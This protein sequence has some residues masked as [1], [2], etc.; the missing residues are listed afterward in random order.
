MTRGDPRLGAVHCSCR[1]STLQTTR[2]SPP[3]TRDYP[4]LPEITASHQAEPAAFFS[5]AAATASGPAIRL[6]AKPSPRYSRDAVEI[7]PRYRRD[8]S[9]TQS[10]SRRDAAEVQ[11]RCRRG[12]GE[13]QPRYSR[14][15]DLRHGCRRHGRC[16]PARR[17]RH[18]IR[19]AQRAAGKRRR[20]RLGRVNR[21]PSHT[22]GTAGST[23]R[24][25]T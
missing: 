16:R 19:R 10:R 23:L 3:I 18:L 9:E 15:T 7:S 2:R 8:L 25:T 17:S 24:C 4:R 11:S 1:C 5:F 21:S 20:S 13:V 12:A 14:E 6:Q 22:A